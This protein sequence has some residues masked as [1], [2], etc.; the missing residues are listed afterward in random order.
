M[1]RFKFITAARAALVFMLLS[2]CA[3]PVIPKDLEGQVDRNV[4]FLQVKEAPSSYQHRTI[5]LGGEVLS[6]TRDG[7]NT[8]VEVLQLPLDRSLE[9]VRDRQKSLGRFL[10]V[11]NGFVDPATLPPGTLV[12]II[13]E[14]TGATKLPIG[15]TEYSYPTLAVKHV[16]LWEPQAPSYPRS[17]V[18]IGIGGGVGGRGGFGGVGGGIGF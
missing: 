15:E 9:P 13:G 7:D 14:V 12:T 11:H 17:G 16:K 2:A 10:G 8:R 5:A 6:V 18:S 1:E 4:S 3:P